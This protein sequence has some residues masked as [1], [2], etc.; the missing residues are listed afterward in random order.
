[1]AGRSP[2]SG[3]VGGRSVGCGLPEAGG[4]AAGRHAAGVDHV[5]VAVY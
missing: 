3:C 4:E 2:W 1:M 5:A